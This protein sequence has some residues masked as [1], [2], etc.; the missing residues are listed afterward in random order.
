MTLGG[1][2]EREPIIALA[3]LG[4]VLATLGTYLANRSGRRSRV[5]VLLV[6]SGYALTLASVAAFILAGFLSGR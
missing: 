6:R 2:L 1:L 3:I 5:P 4:A